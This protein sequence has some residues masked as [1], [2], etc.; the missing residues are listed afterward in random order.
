MI[1]DRVLRLLDTSPLPTWRWERRALLVLEVLCGALTV[2]AAPT[3]MA[4]CILAIAA[5]VPLQT[6]TTAEAQPL[7]GELG[8]SIVEAQPLSRSAHPGPTIEAAPLASS[9]PLVRSSCGSEK[10]VFVA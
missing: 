1:S 2:W 3:L 7:P 10:T 6:P 9:S 4:R 8:A 5:P